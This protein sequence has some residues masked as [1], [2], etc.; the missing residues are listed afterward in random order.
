[1]VR[2]KKL[3]VNAEGMND[4]KGA[5]PRLHRLYPTNQIALIYRL[6]S[7]VFRLITP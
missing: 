2:L 7:I 4:L 6:S 5:L 3:K 1:M